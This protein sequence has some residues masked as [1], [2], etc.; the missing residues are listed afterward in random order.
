MPVDLSS[1]YVEYD[2][3][4]DE[5]PDVFSSHE[6]IN[7]LMHKNQRAFVEALYEYREGDEPFRKLHAQLS[8]KLHD[9]EGTVAVTYVGHRNSPTV[10]GEMQGCAFWQKQGATERSPQTY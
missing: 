3:V 1:L 10:F 2:P 6:F 9:H 5:M 4:L 7:R 8:Q